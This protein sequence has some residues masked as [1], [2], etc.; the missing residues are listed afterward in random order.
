MKTG[1]YRSPA[2]TSEN[3]FSSNREDGRKTGYSEKGVQPLYK[4]RQQS[5]RAG[6]LET[7]P[8]EPLIFE[9]KP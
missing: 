7:V 5:S 4:N 9:K 1:R 8:V 3:K 6:R 2:L